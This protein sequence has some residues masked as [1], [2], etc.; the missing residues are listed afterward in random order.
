ME[1]RH[2]QGVMRE[3]A[4]GNMSGE[5]LRAIRKALRMKQVEFARALGVHPITVSDYE[6]GK[7]P[8]P[9]LVET[10]AKALR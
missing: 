3:R 7:K 9:K 8:I 6:R 2:L 4:L 10:A 1:G 5:E